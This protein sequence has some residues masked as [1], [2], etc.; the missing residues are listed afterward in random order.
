MKVEN[1]ELDIK[2]T[3]NKIIFLDIDKPIEIPFNQ[4]ISTDKQRDKFIKTIKAECRKSMEYKDL[5]AYLKDNLNMTECEFFT[6]V[7]GK[8]RKGVIE[9][10]HEPFTLE[11]V[12]SIV[13]AKHEKL[14]GTLDDLDICEEVMELHYK[15]EIGLIPLSVTAHEL[16]DNNQLIIPLNCVYGRFIE[17]VDEYYDYI[18]EPIQRMLLE[19]MKASKNITREDFSIL[20]VQYVYTNVDGYS[21]PQKI[22]NIDDISV[23]SNEE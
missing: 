12:I 11:T 3:S 18:D 20:D 6:G 7:S 8:K 9:I 23:T 15:G 21:L 22:T 5:I 17:F 2:N 14:Y 4:P 1:K 16:A 13:V 19:K 10:H